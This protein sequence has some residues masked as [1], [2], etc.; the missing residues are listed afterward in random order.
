MVIE[1]VL[2][3]YLHDQDPRFNIFMRDNIILLAEQ[4]GI[5]NF[6]YRVFST[7]GDKKQTAFDVFAKTD[8]YVIEGIKTTDSEFV[9]RNK[10][11]IEDQAVEGALHLWF[12]NRHATPNDHRFTEMI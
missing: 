12:M 4:F 10:M 5:T 7:F 2:F 1:N 8:N 3:D 6:A 9:I 11:T